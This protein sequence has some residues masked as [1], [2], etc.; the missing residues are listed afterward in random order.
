MTKEEMIDIIV[1]TVEYI[2]PKT[3]VEM[4]GKDVC[5]IWNEKL[6]AGTY[7]D[8]PILVKTIETFIRDFLVGKEN[9]EVTAIYDV[10][11]KGRI[12]C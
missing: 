8:K 11:V 2:E 12:S 1:S 4:F 9:D 3:F 7:I 6:P 5:D 10:F